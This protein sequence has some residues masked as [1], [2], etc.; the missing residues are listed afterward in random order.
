M[1]MVDRFVV[2]LTETSMGNF[3]FAK[4]VLELVERGHLVIKSSSFKVKKQY[5]L[6]YFNYLIL[7]LFYQCQS[8]GFSQEIVAVLF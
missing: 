3:L 7:S 6:V 8:Q 2:H 5:V 1:S 4:L